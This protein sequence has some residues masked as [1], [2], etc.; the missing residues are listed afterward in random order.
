L[1]EA[2]FSNKE[3]LYGWLLSM[4]DQIELMEPKELRKDMEGLAMGI[5][6]KYAGKRKDLLLAANAKEGYNKT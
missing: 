1:F 2:G 3:N 4:G 5:Y 6:E